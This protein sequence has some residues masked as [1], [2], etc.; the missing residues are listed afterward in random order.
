MMVLEEG[1]FF[2]SEVNL[3]QWFQLFGAQRRAATMSLQLT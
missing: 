3:Y 2:M 1:C